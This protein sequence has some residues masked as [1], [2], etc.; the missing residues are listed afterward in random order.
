MNNLHPNMLSDSIELIIYDATQFLFH[1]HFS[2]NNGNNELP[3]IEAFCVSL[4]TKL[5]TR[6]RYKMV[7]NAYNNTLLFTAH[8]I[9]ADG[10]SSYHD[11]TFVYELSLDTLK[12]SKLISNTKNEAIYGAHLCLM[13]G[14]N[15]LL[16]V[17]GV[18]AAGDKL[19]DVRVYSYEKK[20]RMEDLPPMSFAR[21][22]NLSCVVDEVHNE[23]IVAG[24]MKDK[25]HEN[26]LEI[27]NL[28]TLKWVPYNYIFNHNHREPLLFVD[29]E[30]N[31]EQQVVYV[32]G[33]EM[34]N[35]KRIGFVECIDLRQN[36]GK[37]IIG[38]WKCV[39][40]GYEN[41]NNK[42]INISIKQMFQVQNN[43][44]PHVTLLQCW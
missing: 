31:E 28:S 2:P 38:K 7:Y 8:S 22:E 21:S 20:Q 32:A 41:T 6:D 4:P 35:F 10:V 34:E 43:Y 17:G 18:N 16:Q 44:S 29:F 26:K 24:G 27:L 39:G 14:G 13:Q 42:N 1:E 25:Y 3:M 15:A 37:T 36:Y 40:G 19:K 33:N 11:D 12:W 5:P 23:L 9:S 30:N